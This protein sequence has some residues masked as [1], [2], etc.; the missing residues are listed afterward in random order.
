MVSP[1]HLGGSVVRL[2]VGI[3][4]CTLLTCCGE[5]PTVGVQSGQMVGTATPD[6]T[7]ARPSA[8]V[9]ESTVPVTAPPNVTTTLLVTTTVPVTAPPNATT[10]GVEAVTVDTSSDVEVERT[11]AE[12]RS[13][14]A[15]DL[16]YGVE[17]LYALGSVIDVASHPDGGLYAATF[18][19]TVHRYD[20]DSGSEG[21]VLDIS[22]RIRR[23]GE[24]GL[25]SIAV[26]PGGG[27]LYLYYSTL[28]D[29]DTR[30]A[31]F[32]LDTHRADSDGEV[33]LFDFV[34]PAAV[35]NGGGLLVRPDGTLWLS[36]G[37]GGLEGDPEDRAQDPLSLFGKLLRIVPTPWAE[38]PFEVP[39]DNPFVDVEGVRAEIWSLGLRNVWRFDV[40]PATGDVW[41]SDVGK[42]FVEEVNFSSM[43]A[44]GENY[45]W[46][47]LEG[48]KPFQGT[49]PEPRI[50]PLVELLHGRHDVCS[51]LGGLV[52]RGDRH[53][54]LD[55]AY[56]FFDYCQRV[57]YAAY[58]EAGELVELVTLTSLPEG[59]TSVASG[60]DGDV[61]I[62][63]A[64]AKRPY[65]LSSS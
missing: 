43:S 10:T 1:D 24:A 56:L 63:G 5:R 25:L 40:D 44:G 57:L 13:S 29:L 11:S 27:W 7:S 9:P 53:P 32:P 46:A 8:S 30:L 37:D 51:M 39:N 16:H 54:E 64:D 26:D 50:D 17:P 35:H 12:S 41:T 4:F 59:S 61:L 48:T 33:A 15:R 20:P 23:F 2:L 3:G 52:Y 21:I 34:Q 65:R 28:S 60:L 45:G 19:G 38:R 58:Q 47:R 55:G 31:A 62:L 42:D 22:D 14:T 36:V 6:P 49:A 18:D